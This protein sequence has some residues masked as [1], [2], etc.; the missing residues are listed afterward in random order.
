TIPAYSEDGKTWTA[1]PQCPTAGTLPAGWPDCYYRAADG[2]LHILTIHATYYA[3]LKKGSKVTAALVL[4]ATAKVAANKL[5]LSVR[6]TLPGTVK[7]TLEHKGKALASW[8]RPVATRAKSLVLS[9]P[10]KARA[11]GSYVL[12]LDLKVA[13]EHAHQAL[14]VKVAAPKKH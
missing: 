5:K 11:A 4:H 3:L 10:A 13:K 7:L 12:V 1:I 8:S 9:L 14:T 2:T 6:A